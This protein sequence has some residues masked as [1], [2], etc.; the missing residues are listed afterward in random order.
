MALFWLWRPGGVSCGEIFLLAPPAAGFVC[1]LC[2]AGCCEKNT[3]L[4]VEKRK[5]QV[6]LAAVV[7]SSCYQTSTTPPE[8]EEL[9]ADLTLKIIAIL[10]NGPHE[11]QVLR[12]L[13]W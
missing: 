10:G 5:K 11:I 1:V 8:D 4:V 3:Q 6:F 9:R 7:C 12:A 2:V 13:P